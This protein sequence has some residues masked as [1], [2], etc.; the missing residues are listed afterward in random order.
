MWGRYDSCIVD[1]AIRKHAIIHQLKP[2]NTILMQIFNRSKK[3]KSKHRQSIR[4]ADWIGDRVEVGLLGEGDDGGR[5]GE[6]GSS[7]SHDGIG[8]GNDGHRPFINRKKGGT[9]EQRMIR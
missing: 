3:K 7:V 4:K 5:V 9:E 6:D 8:V 1:A 2:I